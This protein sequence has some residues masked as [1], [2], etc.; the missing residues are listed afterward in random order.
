MYVP[1]NAS[2]IVLV[3][4]FDRDGNLVATPEQQWEALDAFIEDDSYLSDRRGKYTER[5]QSRTPFESIVDLRILQDFYL[6]M[7]NGKRNT[8]QLSLDIFNVGNL[9]SSSWGKRYGR[10]FSGYELLQFEG[11]AEGSNTPTYTFQA[12]DEDR[13]FSGDNEAFFG[14]LDDSGVLSSRWQMQ[15]GVRY[16][17]GN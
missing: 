6:E 8:L 7:G 15:L 16:I 14:D 1:R 2:E 17:F 13:A 12:F 5:N 9:I 10:Q 3:D 11:F 4:L